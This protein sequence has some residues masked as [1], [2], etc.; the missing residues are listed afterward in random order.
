MKDVACAEGKEV[1]RATNSL[2]SYSYTKT[3]FLQVFHS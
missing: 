3:P 2:S 1:E